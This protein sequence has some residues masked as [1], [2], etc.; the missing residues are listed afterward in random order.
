MIAFIIENT[1]DFKRAFGQMVNY[2]FESPGALSVWEW[3][4]RPV[5]KKLC[6]VRYL[7][8]FYRQVTNQ[9]DGI[10]T[11]GQQQVYTQHPEA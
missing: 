5:K 11:Y 4:V 6:G 7:V 10:R 8:Q 2:T 9:S 3:C 1:P